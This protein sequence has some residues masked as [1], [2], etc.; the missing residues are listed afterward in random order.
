MCLLSSGSRVRI[1]PGAP[2]RN[3]SSRRTSPGRR[4]LLT[5]FSPAAVPAA[6]PMAWSRTGP[7]RPPRGC[8]ARPR[9][10][11]AGRHCR[12]GRPW[13]R[14]LSRR[15]RCAATGPALPVPGSGLGRPRPARP[16]HPGLGGRADLTGS[17]G[18]HT[19]TPR[20]R[21]RGLPLA[22]RMLG[23]VRPVLGP[24]VRGA[25]AGRACQGP[26]NTRRWRR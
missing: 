11:A 13:R 18:A 19:A 25:A 22:Q 26:R 24:G 6:C 14:G 16:R 4:V 9:W 23:Q 7:A 21:R 8:S 20:G 3:R 15:H 1:L 17:H 12:A 2:R 5:M 10:P